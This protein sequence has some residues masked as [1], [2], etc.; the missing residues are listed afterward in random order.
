MK[1]AP[2]IGP[3]RRAATRQLHVRSLGTHGLTSLCRPVR[4]LAVGTTSGKLEPFQRCQLT[5]TSCLSPSCDIEDEALH[6][7]HSKARQNCLARPCN[8]HDALPA[9]RRHPSHSKKARLEWQRYSSSHPPMWRNSRQATLRSRPSV[10]DAS[11]DKWFRCCPRSTG[12]LGGAGH[13]LKR[14]VPGTA[15]GASA[16]LNQGNFR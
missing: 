7:M 15:C 8:S 9:G 16:L 13:S 4:W 2:H 14:K 1:N 11:I 3:F 6:P 10:I 12:F 5:V